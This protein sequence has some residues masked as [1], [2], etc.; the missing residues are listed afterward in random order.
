MLALAA[1][2]A[3]AWPDEYVGNWRAGVCDHGHGINLDL[4]PDPIGHRQRARLPGWTQT[5][6]DVG[7]SNRKNVSAR[8]GRALIGS[9][10]GVI[11]RHDSRLVAPATLLTKCLPGRDKRRTR[12]RPPPT[13]SPP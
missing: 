5:N 8:C 11:E 2:R 12:T 3:D 13:F 9:G 6:T 7:P 1:C 4:R 10:I